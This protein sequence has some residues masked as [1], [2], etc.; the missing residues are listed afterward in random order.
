MQNK[1]T[2]LDGGI[3][4][5]GR[6]GRCQHEYGLK[7]IV[8]PECNIPNEVNHNKGEQEIPDLNLAP[9]SMVINS[10]KPQASDAISSS[11]DDSVNQLMETSEEPALVLAFQAPPQ[12]IFCILK[13]LL[14][15]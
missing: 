3:G 8:A 11:T 5:G 14:K 6:A 10:Y 1:I 7:Y 2:S 4:P 15:I 13:F 9:K 12:S